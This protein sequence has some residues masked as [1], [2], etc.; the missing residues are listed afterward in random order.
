M[1]EYFARLPD[2]LIGHLQLTMVALLVG[3]AISV[4]LGVWATRSKNLERV[5]MGLASVVQT[6]PGLALLAVMVPLLSMMSLSG[7]GMM[8]ALIGLTLYSLLP[9]LRNTVTGIREVDPALKEAAIGVGM[10]P[11]QQLRMV[12]L[13]LALPMIVA[14]I[15]TAAVWVVGTAT[16]STAV[17]AP[18]LGNYIFE[19]LQLR[20]EGKVLFGCAAAAVLALSLDGLIRLWEGSVQKR[21]RGSTRVVYGVLGVA[22][23]WVGVSAFGG[24]DV[25]SVRIGTKTFTEQYVLGEVMAQ[26][27][28]VDGGMGT[29]LVPSLGSTVVFDALTRGE[30]DV[31]V[32]YSGTIWSTVMKRE[33]NPGRE[34]VLAE[35]AEYLETE[36]DV[37]SLGSLGFQNSYALA[38]RRDT[39]EA[40]RLVRISDL[41]T[42]AGTMVIGGDYEFFGRPEWTALTATYEFSFK[43]ERSMDASLMYQAVEQGDVDLISAFS[44]DGR[45]DA[46]D[47]VVLEDDRGAIPPYD[48]V[49]LVNGA[50]AREYP[51]VVD[52]LRPLIGSIDDAGMRKLNRAV[53]VDGQAPAEVAA[54]LA[55]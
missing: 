36:H 13:P 49:L 40:H 18:S 10:T 16:L 7:I 31:Y 17:G 14:G 38:V 24:S 42:I 44:T 53:D 12:E 29:E 39:A 54:S 4:P 27:V 46:F 21:R 23:L 52:A 26:T 2:L 3:T 19:G 15:R 48:A 45:I 51:S 8:P 41:R 1:S 43:G 35:V 50:F 37:V 11:K 25:R 22:Y 33:Q 34:Q 28:R 6:I 9:I 32:D 30:I 47:L 20:D 55:R 5:V